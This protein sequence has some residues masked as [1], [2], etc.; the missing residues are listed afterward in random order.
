MEFKK[1][2]VLILEENQTLRQAL[3]RIVH[4]QD[5]PFTLNIT[6]SI[7][8]AKVSLNYLPP[9]AVIIDLS[10][11]Q[12]AE[13]DL[14]QHIKNTPGLSHI[15]IILWAADDTLESQRR[16]QELGVTKYL[17]KPTAPAQLLEAIVSVL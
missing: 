2:R 17:I 4:D 16:A 8:M 13:F 11:T 7:Q 12:L 15:P 1:P 9:S 6:T 5:P 10:V 3:R 14:I